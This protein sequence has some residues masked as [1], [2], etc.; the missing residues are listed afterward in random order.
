MRQ[1]PTSELRVRNEMV[2]LGSTVLFVLSVVAFVTYVSC[3]TLLV[4]VALG[5][6]VVRVRQGTLLGTGIRVSEHQ[7]PRIHNLVT[8]AA[9]R[10]G[11]APP[12]VFVV[13]SAALNAYAIGVLGK[14]SV[15]LHSATVEGLTEEELLFVIGHE[16]CHVKC[17]HT[18]WLVLTSGAENVLRIPL[19][20]E[21]VGLCFLW[22]SRLAEYTCDRGGLVANRNPTAAIAALAKIAVGPRLF[23]ELD[24]KRLEAQR[25]DVAKDE[26]A[27]WSEALSTH[28]YIVHRFQAIQEFQ[29]SDLYRRLTAD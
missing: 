20:T 14:K 28:P 19:V 7:L 12:D 11:M 5:A 25:E 22:W 23:Q 18:S 24:L 17:G 4:L 29:A 13:Q 9:D 1:V 6:V 8:T 3:G 2:V 15:V 21:L 27:R 26:V 10:L 16:L